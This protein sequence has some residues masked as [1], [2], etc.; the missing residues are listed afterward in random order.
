[1]RLIAIGILSLTLL[2]GC[3]YPTSTVRAVD[4]RPAIAI[5]GASKGAILLVDGVQMGD[6]SAFDGD[7]K[8]LVLEP[9]THTVEI[10]RGGVVI[11]SEKVFLGRRGVTTVSVGS[12]G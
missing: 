10:Q 11:Y 6:A 7:P 12:G 8:V 9:G 5:S 4:E 2:G 3:T 1:M